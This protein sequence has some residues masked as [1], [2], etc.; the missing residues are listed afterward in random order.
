MLYPGDHVVVRFMGESRDG[1]LVQIYDNHG[2]PWA[3][4]FC[5]ERPFPYSATIDAPL[6][7]YVQIPGPRDRSVG[8]VGHG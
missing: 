6:S 7:D 1:I 2:E 5:T 3:T 4:M 8:Q